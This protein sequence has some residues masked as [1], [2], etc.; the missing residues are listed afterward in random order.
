MEGAA[1][2]EGMEMNPSI[3]VIPK[4]GRSNTVAFTVLLSDQD[5]GNN[6]EV[7]KVER[8]I[9]RTACLVGVRVDG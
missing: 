5:G 1:K 9:P 4:S 8:S 7:D 6:E 3:Q 2:M